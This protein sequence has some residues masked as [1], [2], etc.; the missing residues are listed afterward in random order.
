MIDPYADDVRFIH[1]QPGYLQEGRQYNL[2]I[3]VL[4]GAPY[5]QIE[6]PFTEENMTFIRHA[7]DRGNM[8]HGAIVHTLIFHSLQGS[9]MVVVN[10]P[11]N[12]MYRRKVYSDYTLGEFT[13]PGT[14][15]W[16]AINKGLGRGHPFLKKEMNKFGGKRKNTR[17]PKKKTRKPKK[18]TQK[19][20]TQKNRKK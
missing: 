9:E 8:V 20:K 14:D 16:R 7:E 5:E 1:V 6:Q 4:P 17:K 11:R 2:V 10:H 15:G 13:K 3:N 19:K 18:K 12:R